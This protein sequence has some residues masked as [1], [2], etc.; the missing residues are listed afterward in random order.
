MAIFSH[1]NLI[2]Q[3]ATVFTQKVFIAAQAWE[4]QVLGT[5]APEYPMTRSS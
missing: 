4:L 3:R 5:A 2:P 1:A